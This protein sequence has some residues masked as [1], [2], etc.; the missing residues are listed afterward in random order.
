MPHFLRF[1]QELETRLERLAERTG[2]SKTELIE[3][4][5]RDGVGQLESE[6]MFEETPHRK[7]SDLSIDQLLRESG[8]GI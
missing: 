4:L 3:R 6:L 8:L 5:V 1:S 2:F 7:P